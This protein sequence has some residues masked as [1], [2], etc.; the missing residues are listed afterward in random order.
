MGW[1]A[2]CGAAKASA[3]CA[4]L[5][6]V[7]KSRH[8]RAK[9]GGPCQ[10]PPPTMRCA[11]GVL[12]SSHFGHLDLSYLLP[13]LRVHRDSTRILHRLKKASTVRCKELI[14]KKN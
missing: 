3:V 11:T 2:E 14:L 13:P 6:A 8:G 4:L 12:V 1:A 7:P 9:T 10:R 5:P